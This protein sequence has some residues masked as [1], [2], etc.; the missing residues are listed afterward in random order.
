MRCGCNFAAAPHTGMVVK[1]GTFDSAS[2]APVR[3]EFGWSD[4]PLFVLLPMVLVAI[5]SGASNAG[6]VQY[7]TKWPHIAH[8]VMI[9]IPLWLSAELFS[10]ISARVLVPW[11]VVPAVPLILGALIATQLNVFF[12]LFR[13]WVL[14]PYLAPGS[15]YFAIWPWNYG[16][17]T[18]RL[19]AALTIS[20]VILYWLLM[21]LAFLRIFGFSR[22]GSTALFGRKFAVPAPAPVPSPDQTPRQAPLSATP[23][24]AAPAGPLLSRLPP[25][26]GRDIIALSAQEHY[27]QV[28][29]STGSTLVLMRFADAITAAEAVTSGA[30]VHRSHWVARH[31]VDGVEGEGARMVLRLN[32]GLK[33]PVS[34]SYRLQTRG[35]LGQD[36]K[37]GLA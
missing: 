37:L 9:A 12:S 32:N 19:E 35:L 3:G 8:T 31:A 25:T 27:T 23:P 5:A 21:N 18:Y 11:Q 15:H 22:F 36:E 4:F 16:D 7:V 26:I 28:H 2:P 30:R 34:R 1:T 10:R 24:P 20:Q 29:S 14:T 33:I 6:S 13:N 17:A